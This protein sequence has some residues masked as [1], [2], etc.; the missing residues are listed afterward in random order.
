MDRRLALL[1]ILGPYAL[2]GWALDIR[3]SRH[4]KDPLRGALY[5]WPPNDPSLYT[6]EG[7]RLRRQANRFYLRGG[8]IA[9]LILIAIFTLS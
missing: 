7:V 5:R 1:L 4:L 6:P 3:A 2:I 8:L 9:I